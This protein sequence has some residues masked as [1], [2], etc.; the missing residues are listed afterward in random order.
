MLEEVPADG[1]ALAVFIGREIQLAR[2]LQD[3]S[4]VLHHLLAP[5]S[6]LVGGLEAVVDVDR[7]TLRRQVGHVPHRS[8]HVEGISEETRDGLG[9][10]GRFDNDEGLG[11][12]L[13]SLGEGRHRCQ[14]SALGR[15][16]T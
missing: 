11:H 15:D 4:Q 1:L 10:R 3:G 14:G 12:V 8:A 2:V 6:Q 16:S 5:L 9:L 7:Q 13:S